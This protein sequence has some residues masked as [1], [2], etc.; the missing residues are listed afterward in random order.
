M[1]G[2]TPPTLGTDAFR[3]APLK[4]IIVPRGSAN[5]YKTATN[6]SNFAEI[7]TEG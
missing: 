7:I 6:W 5:A 2:Q 1:K 3:S 4:S